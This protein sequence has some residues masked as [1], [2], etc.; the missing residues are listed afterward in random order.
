MRGDEQEMVMPNFDQSLRLRRLR[1]L[2]FGKGNAVSHAKTRDRRFVVE[3][4]EERQ[5][6]SV[7]ALAGAEKLYEPAEP[8]YVAQNVS[9][10][11]TDT[12]SASLAAALAESG[13]TL[14]NTAENLSSV[15]NS[16]AVID[17]Q[18]SDDMGVSYSLDGASLTLEAD[19]PS[20]ETQPLREGRVYGPMTYSE[21]L[22]TLPVEPQGGG[23]MMLMSCG[24]GGGCSCLPPLIWTIY[25]GEGVGCGPFDRVYK[26]STGASSASDTWFTMQSGNTASIKAEGCLSCCSPGNDCTSVGIEVDD[27]NKEYF[28]TKILFGTGTFTWK[29]PDNVANADAKRDFTFTY[30]QDK[31]ANGVRDAGETLD[32]LD[33]HIGYAEIWGWA[34]QAVPGTDAA[35]GPD[36]NFPNDPNRQCTGHGSWEIIVE[37]ATVGY[38]KQRVSQDQIALLDTYAN[39]KWGWGAVNERYCYD[40][41]GEFDISL[42]IAETPGK[43]RCD[44]DYE[45]RYDPDPSDDHIIKY[46]YDVKKGWTISR[47]GLF[48]VMEYTQTLQQDG[49]SGKEI[50]HLTGNNCIVKAVGAI[51]R[52]GIAFTVTP[53]TL[54][55]T[56]WGNQIQIQLLTPGGFGQALLAAGGELIGT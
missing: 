16:P 56:V 37:E 51:N 10:D 7:T 1:V 29:K 33:A 36:P 21:Y 22:A 24:C 38:L 50:Y 26:S 25:L 49:L 46:P 35:W 55:I 2:F 45:T 12:T 47:D 44:D 52:A 8:G 54:P 27:P 31:N 30:F 13:N 17:E 40:D 43:L 5:L 14:E 32:T 11:V 34:D 20:G 53:T 42:A 23:G 41:D 4:L 39:H 3:N 15:E 6:L 48:S 28:A 18:L 19:I 9:V